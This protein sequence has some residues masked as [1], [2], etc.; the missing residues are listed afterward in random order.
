MRSDG[1]P[2]E[3]IDGGGHRLRPESSR[4]AGLLE[5]S[6]HGLKHCEYTT[7]GAAIQRVHPGRTLLLVCADV[8]KVL[9]HLVR[10]ELLGSIR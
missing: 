5:L 10:H 9:L 3:D 1:G 4:S 7:F 8:V 6:A 2:I